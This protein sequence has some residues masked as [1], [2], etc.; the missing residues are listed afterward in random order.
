[1]FLELIATVFAGLAVAGVVM[2]LN[3]LIGN[4]LPR[5]S[6]PV[7]AG[8]GMIATTI[9][10][11]Y[12][13]YGRTSAALPEGMEIAQ[14]VENQSFYRPWTYIRPYV[15]RF[16]AVDATSLREN[17]AVPGQRMMDL[18]FYGRWSPLNKL[19]VLLDCKGARRASLADG[20]EFG[21]DG[22]VTN[23]DWVQVDADDPVLATGCAVS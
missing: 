6:I 17:P 15:D 23:A 10:N 21:A 19:T 13:W 1:M 3:K 20:A 14:T 12:G 18:Y 9:S 22:Q 8:L 4:R 7:A 2:L 5:W 11:E 16:V